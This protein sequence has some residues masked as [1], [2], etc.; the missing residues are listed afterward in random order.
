MKQQVLKALANPPRIFYVPYS[1]AVLNFVVQFIV[2]IAIYVSA[3]VFFDFQI[4]PLF[5]LISVL[6]VHMLLAVYS[7][8][9]PQLGQILLAKIQLFKR[10][11][12][13]RLAA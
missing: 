9:D 11:I 5:F 7:R 13:R 6:G 2:F 1:L 12:P 10:K 8:V 4:E 3:L